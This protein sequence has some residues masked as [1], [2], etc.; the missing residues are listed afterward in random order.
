MTKKDVHD[1]GVKNA[2]KLDRN[3][4]KRPHCNKKQQGRFSYIHALSIARTSSVGIASKRE[5]VEIA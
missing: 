5:M 1:Q 3:K 4:Q 2:E